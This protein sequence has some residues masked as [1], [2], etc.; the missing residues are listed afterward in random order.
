MPQLIYLI[1]IALEKSQRVDESRDLQ[2][3][4]K[5]FENR[6]VRVFITKVI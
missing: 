2:G 1:S 4:N 5:I 6:K 3:L